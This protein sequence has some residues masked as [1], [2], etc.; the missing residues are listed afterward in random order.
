LSKVARGF[1]TDLEDVVFLLR[2]NVI[3]LEQLE[4]YVTAALPQAWDFDIE[5][6]D[7]QQHL[8]AVCKLLGV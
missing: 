1:E 8:A 2:Q 6:A 4:D 5:P 7:M 3:N